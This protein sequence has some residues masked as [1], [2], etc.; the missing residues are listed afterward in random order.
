MAID[1]GVAQDI[2]DLGYLFHRRRWQ[3][4][5]SPVLSTTLAIF[6]LMFLI[7]RTSP[8]IVHCISLKSAPIGLIAALFSGVSVLSFQL[9]VWV[10]F[11]SKRSCAF[12]IF[13]ANGYHVFV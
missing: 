12:S 8:K 2:T 5:T 3:H 13:D 7:F 4:D 6:Q 11:F 1:D 9:M 10:I